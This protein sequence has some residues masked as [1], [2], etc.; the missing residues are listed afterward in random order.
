LEKR[1]STIVTFVWDTTGFARGNY[2]LKVCVE[3]VQGET[4]DTDNSLTSSTVKVVIPG[5]VNAD[6]KVE[7]MD[8]FH[9]S[10]AYLSRPGKSNWN[11]NADINDD[12]IVEMMDFFIMSQ[13]YLE[14]EP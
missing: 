2:T 13:H 8:F 9:A 12:G 10:N 5:D 14:H 7:L 6:G 3:P 1:E 11:P 4:D